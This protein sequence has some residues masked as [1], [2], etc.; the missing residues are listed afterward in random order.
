MNSFEVHLW[1][2]SSMTRDELIASIEEI[3]PGASYQVVIAG[4]GPEDV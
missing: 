2:E 3:M 4:S 1:F